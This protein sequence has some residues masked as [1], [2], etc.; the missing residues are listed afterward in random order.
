MMTSWILLYAHDLAVVADLLE[1][2]IP[3]LATWS[4]GVV[5]EFCYIGDMLSAGD[6]FELAV[7]T[8]C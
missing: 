3:M 2:C 4:L 8:C 5:Q 1:E 6:G 7:I